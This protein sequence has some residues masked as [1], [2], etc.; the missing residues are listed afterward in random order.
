VDSYQAREEQGG[1]QTNSV[2]AESVESPAVIS[3]HDVEEQTDIDCG[4]TLQ[5]R[6]DPHLGPE[7]T[8][9]PVVHLLNGGN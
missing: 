6:K 8:G 3:H 5:R 1:Y 9:F 2:G 4:V 7:I